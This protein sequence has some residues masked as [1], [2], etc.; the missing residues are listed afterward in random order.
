MTIDQIVVRDIGR[1]EN[2][3]TIDE[4]TT[5]LV[6][7]ILS[8]AIKAAP[9]QIPSIMLS[10]IEGGLSSLTHLDFGNVQID[11]GT[12]LKNLIGNIKD[13]GS[14]VGGIENAVGGIGKGIGDLIDGVTGGEERSRTDPQAIVD[15]HP[16]RARPI[17]HRPRLE[18]A[19][20]AFLAEQPL[21]PPRFHA[22]RSS[23]MRS[24]ITASR[25]GASGSLPRIDREWSPPHP[26]LRVLRQLEQCGLVDDAS[27]VRTIVIAAEIDRQGRIAPSRPAMPRYRS[28]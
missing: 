21:A 18:T 3:V 4:V 16:G 10:T 26:R 14:K 13:V 8:S 22:S 19:P 24:G 25:A 7:S 11:L 12:G 15:L 17:D 27:T 23:P 2:G 9:E 1:K 6:R 20:G 28:T 5:I